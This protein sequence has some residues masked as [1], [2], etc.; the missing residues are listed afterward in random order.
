MSKPVQNGTPQETRDLLARWLGI[1]DVNGATLRALATEVERAGEQVESLSNRLYDRIT[2]M[3]ELTRMDHLLSGL[4]QARTPEEERLAAELHEALA[5]LQHGDK[6]RQAM[7]QA[8]AVLRLLAD[9]G[10]DLAAETI[11]N[12]HTLRSAGLAEATALRRLHRDVELE[13][14]RR[15]L[16]DALGL[17]VLEEP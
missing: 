5:E 16:M 8:A 17:G 4:N 10:L 3:A 11:G 13:S 1:S 2:T 12:D 6:V 14:L 15:K 9:M 7:R